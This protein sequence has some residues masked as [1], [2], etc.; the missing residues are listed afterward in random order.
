MQHDPA[1]A[2]G[3]VDRKLFVG[4]LMPFT[5]E[6]SVGSHFQQFGPIEEVKIIYDKHTNRSKGYGFVRGALFALLSASLNGQ[7]SFRRFSFFFPVCM[8]AFLLFSF[9][10][11]LVSLIRIF[12]LLRW[13]LGLIPQYCE[14]LIYLFDQF[15]SYFMKLRLLLPQRTIRTQPSTVNNATAISRP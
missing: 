3:A 7:H 12:F 15:R 11:S 6:Q 2:P 13:F 5:T 8:Y 10:L 4:G 1:N 9:G 14:F